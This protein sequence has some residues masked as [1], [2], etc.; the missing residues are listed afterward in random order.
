MYLTAGQRVS[1]AVYF[2][3]QEKETVCESRH[4][5]KVLT[6]LLPLYYD[7]C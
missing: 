2:S 5:V 6:L 1:R 3:S 4:V 7:E